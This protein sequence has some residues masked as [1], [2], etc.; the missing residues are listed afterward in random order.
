MSTNKVR[1]EIYFHMSMTFIY[2]RLYLDLGIRYL[3]LESIYMWIN[4]L[5]WIF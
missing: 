5:L 4:T 3:D 2:N 1:G